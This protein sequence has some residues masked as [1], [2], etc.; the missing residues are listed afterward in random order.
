MPAE[1][2]RAV[3]RVRITAVCDHCNYK[4]QGSLHSIYHHLEVARIFHPRTDM[5]DECVCQEGGCGYSRTAAKVFHF[6]KVILR[7]E[8]FILLCLFFFSF[9]LYVQRPCAFTQDCV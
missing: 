8:Y 1:L 7:V 9:F 4:A 2:D 6:F 5:T 3:C